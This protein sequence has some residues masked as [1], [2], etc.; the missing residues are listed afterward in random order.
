MKLEFHI[1]SNSHAARHIR[2]SLFS[3]VC[4]LRVVA[5]VDTIVLHAQPRDFKFEHLGVEQGLSQC[6]VGAIF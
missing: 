4:S 5:S 2:R 1:P 6:T 3:F